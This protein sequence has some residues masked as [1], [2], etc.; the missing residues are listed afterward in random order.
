M[1]IATFIQVTVQLINFAFKTEQN[2]QEKDEPICPHLNI[3]K[4]KY[5][6]YSLSPIHD[7]VIQ[8]ISIPTKQFLFAQSKH[9]ILI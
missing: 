7:L 9:E 2:K 8:L 6:M 3:Y 4:I 1:I 5:S